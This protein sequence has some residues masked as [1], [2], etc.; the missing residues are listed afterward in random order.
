M[1]G[2]IRTD[3]LSGVLQPG[4]YLPAESML[5]KQFELSNKSV[6]RGLDVLVQEGLIVKIDRVGSK[7]MESVQERIRIHFGCNCLAVQ[8]LSAG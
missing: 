7:V 4:A 3:I 8:G 5:A 2:K 6:R 1:V